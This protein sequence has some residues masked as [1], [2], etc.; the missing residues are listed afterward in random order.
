MLIMEMT[1]TVKSDLNPL[2]KQFWPL[3]ANIIRVTLAY[4]SLSI[5]QASLGM[6]GKLMF[7]GPI[8]ATSCCGLTHVISH[9]NHDKLRSL[10]L[11]LQLK[12]RDSESLIIWLMNIQLTGNGA[13][14][15]YM[16]M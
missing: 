3:C 11:F 8:L 14:F 7:M 1:L 2:L 5:N 15:K 13:K 10:S 4:W 12:I 6:A 9:H 16:S